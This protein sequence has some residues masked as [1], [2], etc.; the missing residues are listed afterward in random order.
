MNCNNQLELIGKLSGIFAAEYDT[1]NIMHPI[2]DLLRTNFGID[3]VGM[4]I[5]NKPKD[6]L[7]ILSLIHI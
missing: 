2:Y 3:I 6:E 1:H 5:Y 4:L 7:I